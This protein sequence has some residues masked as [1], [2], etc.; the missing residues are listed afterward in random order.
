MNIARFPTA[1]VALLVAIAAPL[2]AQDAKALLGRWESTRTS[3]GDVASIVEF[4]PDGKYV[5]ARGSLVR[6]TYTVD[7]VKIEYSMP[8]DQ[9]PLVRGYEVKGDTLTVWS[10]RHPTYSLVRTPTSASREGLVGEW[11]STS[12]GRTTIETMRAD[13]TYRV[14]TQL[15]ANTGEYLVRRN[16]ITI[17]EGRTEMR[18]LWRLTDVGLE[19]QRD[20]NARGSLPSQLWVRERQ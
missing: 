17:R 11:A 1:G 2:T 16:F 8:S 12:N 4:R 3:P 19:L 6:G 10:A 5:M 14:W 15:G 20:V 18:M 9:Q 13:G 7:S